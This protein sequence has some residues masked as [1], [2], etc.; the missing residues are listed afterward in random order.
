M[1]VSCANHD[2]DFAAVLGGLGP[3]RHEL[4][5]LRMQGQRMRQ[6]NLTIKQITA[7]LLTHQIAPRH[8]AVLAQDRFSHA[9]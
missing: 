8:R 2:L 5:L 6:E 7:F 1:L 4:F 9:L 3:L